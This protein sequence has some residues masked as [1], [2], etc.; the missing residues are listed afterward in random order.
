MF[1]SSESKLVLLLA[2]LLVFVLLL[3][4][5]VVGNLTHC[6]HNGDLQVMSSRNSLPR[7]SLITAPLFVRRKRLWLSHFDR[8]VSD[9]VRREDGEEGEEEE[10]EEEIEEEEEEVEEDEDEVEEVLSIT[11]LLLLLV[12]PRLLS[13]AAHV[14]SFL[15]VFGAGV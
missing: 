11:M 9:A 5:L 1:V 14:D 4:V 6:S 15:S 10:G 13:A 8:C 12:V 7:T 3:L 2:V